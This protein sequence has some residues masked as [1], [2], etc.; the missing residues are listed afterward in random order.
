MNSGPDELLE[1]RAAAA[2]SELLEA[3]CEAL[4]RLAWDLYEFIEVRASNTTLANGLAHPLADKIGALHALRL[5][6]ERL[7]R[8][9]AESAAADA[10]RR[11]RARQAEIAA[12]LDRLVAAQAAGDRHRAV[13]TS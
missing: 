7:A 3:R 1:R 6:A 11:E 13:A 8:E 5:E 4:E 2:E 12:D 10:D 9:R